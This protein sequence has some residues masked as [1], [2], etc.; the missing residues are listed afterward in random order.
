MDGKS[1]KE[2]KKKTLVLGGRKWKFMLCLNSYFST[3]ILK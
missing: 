1:G 3:V 2:E